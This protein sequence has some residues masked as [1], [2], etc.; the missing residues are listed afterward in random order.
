MHD[1]NGPFS[2]AHTVPIKTQ[3]SQNAVNVLSLMPRRHASRVPTDPQSH[4]T[5][6]WSFWHGMSDQ[7]HQ[8]KL[9][10]QQA[11]KHVHR[12]AFSTGVV[13]NWDSH[14]IGSVGGL[15]N[16]NQGTTRRALEGCHV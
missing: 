12:N 9:N 1:L 6:T 2:E 5:A 11:R 14:G 16:P 8:W 3:L 4:E 15:S 7:T 13:N 10:K